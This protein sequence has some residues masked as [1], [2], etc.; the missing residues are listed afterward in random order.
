[1][2]C[3][4]PQESLVH[5]DPIRITYTTTGSWKAVD[6]GQCLSGC[7][8]NPIRI[9]IS[10]ITTTGSW[11]QRTGP[12]RPNSPDHLGMYFDYI[13]L[14]RVD[15][16]WKIEAIVAYIAEFHER[17]RSTVFAAIAKYKCAEEDYLD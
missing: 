16:P 3:L 17:K 6:G 12:G 2:T 9:P 5:G 1:M 8:G 11:K 4:K 13:A 15:P 10:S 7:G 14:R